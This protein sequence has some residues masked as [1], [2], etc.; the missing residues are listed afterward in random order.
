[1]TSIPNR[2]FEQPWP[3]GEYRLFQLGFVVDDVI[4]ASARWAATFGVGPFHVLPRRT[5]RATYRGAASAV[6]VQYGIAQAG[7][8]Q[9]ELV[10]Q[11]CD[12]PSMFRDL[13]ERGG[14]G[15]HQ[16][17]TVTQ[18][19]DG[20]AE[21][22]TQLGYELVSEITTPGRRVGYFDTV[23][24]FG[25][26]TEVVEDAPGLLAGLAQIAQTCAEWDGQDPVR[27]LTRDGYD[28]P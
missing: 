13:V 16:V 28:T 12:R 23:A 15:F 21:H 7:P 4:A 11:L 2:M 9:I 8:V 5:S 20:K 27:L 18:D 10:Q 17:C 6:E 26:Y 1:M 19:Y 25:F 14:C 24:D 3:D 22:Y